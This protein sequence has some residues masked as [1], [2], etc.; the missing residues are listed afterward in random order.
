[1]PLLGPANGKAYYRPDKQELAVVP[2]NGNDLPNPEFL[3]WHNDNR[4][5]A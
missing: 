3:R 5:V 4:F 2:S 1:M